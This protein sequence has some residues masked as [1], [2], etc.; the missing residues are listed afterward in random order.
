K[1]FGE[2]GRLYIRQSGTEPLIRVMGE[3]EDEVT[4]HHSINEIIEQIKILL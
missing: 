1:K 3:H 2:K 4:L